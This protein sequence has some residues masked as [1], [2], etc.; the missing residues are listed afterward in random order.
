MFYFYFSYVEVNQIINHISSSLSV[1]QSRFSETTQQIHEL[2]GEM[3]GC[4]SP[5][6]KRDLV[7]PVV[8]GEPAPA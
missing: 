4:G 6:G 3:E 2:G 8:T 5:R 1:S 7:Q